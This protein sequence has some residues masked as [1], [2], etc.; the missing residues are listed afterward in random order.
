MLDF[1]TQRFFGSKK[2]N[3]RGQSVKLTLEQ[4]ESRFL[5]N[6]G[7][8]FAGFGGPALVGSADPAGQSHSETQTLTA[9]LTGAAGTSG[10]ATFTSNSAAGTNN[11]LVQVSGLTANTT[12]SV[13]SGT[14]TLGSIT[15]NAS[16]SGQLSVSNVSPALTAGQS[17]TVLDPSGA[18]VLSGTLAATG[19]PSGSHPDASI[20]GT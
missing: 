16:G 2:T 15:T 6:A 7:P 19:C 20:P 9:T 10:S 5:P 13:T 14:T 17:L 11:L 8:L 3:P 12:Y 1:L 4:F 18:T